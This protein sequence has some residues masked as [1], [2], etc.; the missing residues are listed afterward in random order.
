MAMEIA[1]LPLLRTTES[2]SWTGV[3]RQSVNIAGDSTFASHFDVVRK[4]PKSANDVSKSPVTVPG[5]M[6]L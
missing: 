5:S 6:S 1:D 2:L 4:Q 3:E